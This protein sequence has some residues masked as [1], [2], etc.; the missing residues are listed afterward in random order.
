MSGEEIRKIAGEVIEIDE[1]KSVTDKMRET[2]LVPAGVIMMAIVIRTLE[3]AFNE[4]DAK[5][6]VGELKT[7]LA[8]YNIPDLNISCAENE[9]EIIESLD[10]YSIDWHNRKNKEKEN[11]QEGLKQD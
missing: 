8:D 6:T 4:R 1:I 2:G 9:G 3:Y 11:G 10:I 5:L 7:F